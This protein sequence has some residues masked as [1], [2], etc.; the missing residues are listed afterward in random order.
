MAYSEAQANVCSESGSVAFT[1]A[2]FVWMHDMQY[3]HCR[4]NSKPGTTRMMMSIVGHD[5]R[6]DGEVRM[7]ENVQGYKH[8]IF[9]D[10]QVR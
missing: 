3:C 7:V 8:L 9:I 10:F 5:G 1:S 4:R 6:T 2:V